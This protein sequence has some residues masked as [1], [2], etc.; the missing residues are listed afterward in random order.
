MPTAETVDKNPFTGAVEGGR[1]K[2][3]VALTIAQQALPELMKGQKSAAKTMNDFLARE[4]LGNVVKINE[5]LKLDP[6]QQEAAIRQMAEA[7]ADPSTLFSLSEA[8][9]RVKLMMLA[10]GIERK[11]PVAFEFL[12]EAGVD[13]TEFERVVHHSVQAWIKKSALRIVGRQEAPQFTDLIALLDLPYNSVSAAVIKGSLAY[14]VKATAD[15]R[16]TIGL[17]DQRV[18]EFV[19]TAREVIRI[20][21]KAKA[22]REKYNK[23]TYPVADIMNRASSLRL[24]RDNGLANPAD[25]AAMEEALRADMEAIKVKEE[26]FDKLTEQYLGTMPSRIEESGRALAGSHSIKVASSANARMMTQKAESYYSLA[27]AEALRVLMTHETLTMVMNY[28][29]TKLNRKQRDEALQV[30]SQMVKLINEGRYEEAFVLG[31]ERRLLPEE[32]ADF[33]TGSLTGGREVV[34]EER[35]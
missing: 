4:G 29:I 19:R 33:R 28:V 3:D 17:A 7:I 25:V 16:A 31:A 8:F 1:E 27:A 20:L 15:S 12:K 23:A 32:Y 21:D 14:G 30:I 26:E 9:D 13:V 2:R 35:K 18:G 34:V 24:A 11:M 10:D 5:V 6:T 22:L